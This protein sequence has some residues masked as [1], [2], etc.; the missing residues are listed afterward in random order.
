MCYDLLFLAVKHLSF[1]TYTKMLLCASP[2]DFFWTSQGDVDVVERIEVQARRVITSAR[3]PKQDV[4]GI[5]LRKTPW[6]MTC[7]VFQ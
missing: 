3:E 5:H 2:G 6:Q 7:D 4:F 1:E